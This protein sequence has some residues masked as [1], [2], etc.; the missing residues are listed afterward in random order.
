MRRAFNMMMAIFMLLLL[1][2]LAVLT[3]QYTRIH[4]THFVDSYN[5]E[6]AELFMDSVIEATLLK[7]EGRDRQADGCLRSLLFT[8]ADNRF[9]ANVTIEKYYMFQGKDNNGSEPP[10]GCPVQS[11]ASPMSHGYVE[12]TVVVRSTDHAKVA[13]PIRITRKTL[14]RP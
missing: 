3:M 9:E 5:K 13:T 12:F 11:I 8:S 2:G 7:I 14:Q 6:Q 10:A 1:S 4:A